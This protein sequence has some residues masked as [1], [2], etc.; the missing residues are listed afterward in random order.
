MLRIQCM[1]LLILL[2][3][4]FDLSAQ[5]SIQI[6]VARANAR[7][8]PSSSANIVAVL[9]QGDV[10][11]VVEDVPYWYQIKLAN[12]L[13]PW[14]AKS[15]CTLVLDTEDEEV[16]EENAEPIGDLYAIPD[17]GTP[18]TLQ[19]CTA[20]TLTVNWDICPE[21]G[22][23]QTGGQAQNWR[24]NQKKNRISATCSYFSLAFEKV[25]DLKM[26]PRNVRT[27]PE[28]DPR[29]KYLQTLESRPVVLEGF[30]AMAKKAGK[31]STNCYSSTRKDIHLELAGT[32]QGDPK[33]LRNRVFVTEVSPW[34]SEVNSGWTA[35]NLGQFASYRNGYSGNMQQVPVRVRIYGWLF[36]D[37]PHSGDGSVG[38]WRGTAW[39]LH[40]ITRI[41]VFQN[42]SWL[43]VQ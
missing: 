13:T 10:Y 15:L 9:E 28:S 35:T 12:D 36:Y 37:D 21:G 8:S 7:E 20:T 30:L 29:R 14:V 23:S 16:V 34:F 33:N 1:I 24:S 3:F 27:L 5:S 18:T 11:S 41:E 38:S 2:V 43:A 19:N 40:P 22:T 31:E 6:R 39:E 42:N 32:D 26:L 25:L 4:A 17:F